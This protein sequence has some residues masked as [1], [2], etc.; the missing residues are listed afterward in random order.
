MEK[1]M[2]VWDVDTCYAE[3]FAD[4]VNQKEKVP[5][6]VITFASLEALKEVAT[7]HV[8]EA[9]LLLGATPGMRVGR[10]GAQAGW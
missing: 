10:C 7:S 2:A 1:I 9:L 3:R 6:T 4:V 5:F 8:F